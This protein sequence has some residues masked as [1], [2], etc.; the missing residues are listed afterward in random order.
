MSVPGP[1]HGTDPG[2]AARLVERA[3]GRSRPLRLP[4]PHPR[5]APSDGSPYARI[6]HGWIEGAGMDCSA[7]GTH[8]I[9]RTKAAQVYRK[10]GNLRAVQLLLGH[11]KIPRGDLPSA[12]Y[13]RSPENNKP[14]F[15]GRARRGAGSRTY[16]L[17]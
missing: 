1:D 3:P 12:T 6:V 7:Y 11:T 17:T 16:Y 13:W 15:V 2:L 8:S 9:R 5:S 10:T 14:A 4:E